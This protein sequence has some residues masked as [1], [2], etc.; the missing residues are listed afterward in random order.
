MLE[1]LMCGTIRCQYNIV[2]DLVSGPKYPPDNAIVCQYFEDA[3]QEL[4][5]YCKWKSETFVPKRRSDF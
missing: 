5:D 4:P 1:F 3:H 2:K